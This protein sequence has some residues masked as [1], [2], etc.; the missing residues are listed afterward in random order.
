MEETHPGIHQ[1]FTKGAI[2]VRRTK[3]NFARNPFD[4]TLEEKLNADAASRLTGIRD[5]RQPIAA[6]TDGPLLNL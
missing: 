1:I 2:F 3:N 4:M 6:K 5:F